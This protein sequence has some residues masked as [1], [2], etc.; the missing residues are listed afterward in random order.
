M[1]GGG[2]LLFLVFVGIFSTWFYPSDVLSW[3]VRR[4][5]NGAGWACKLFYTVFHQINGQHVKR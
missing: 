5:G 3:R 4:E 1:G 2:L